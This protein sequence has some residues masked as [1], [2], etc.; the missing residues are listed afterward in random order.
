MFQFSLVC[1]G[2]MSSIETCKLLYG[3]TKLYLGIEV[4]TDSAIAMITDSCTCAHLLVLV[5]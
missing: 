3:Y 2:I 1:T 4:H 5:V